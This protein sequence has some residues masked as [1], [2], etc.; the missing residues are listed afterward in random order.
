MKRA[1]LFVGIDNYNDR[2]I[3]RLNCA[4]NDAFGL[5]NQF[6]YEQFDIVELLANQDAGSVNIID[7]VEDKSIMDVL[8]E[9]L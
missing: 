5:C 2:G 6:A 1:G 8:E 9:L 7:K 3:R 4:Y